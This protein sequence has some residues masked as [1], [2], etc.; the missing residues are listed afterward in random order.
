MRTA[1][2]S[3]IVGGTI[4]GQLRES[5]AAHMRPRIDVLE[6]ETARHATVLDF[7]RLVEKSDHNF[8]SHRP[9]QVA[10]ATRQWSAVLATQVLAQI[11]DDD[12]VY[13]TGEDV[14]FPLAILMQARGIRRPAL[15]VRLEEPTYGRTVWRR[16]VFDLYRHYALRR[17]D[18][19][20]CR[21]TAHSQYLNAIDRVSAGKLAVVGETVDTEFFYPDAP[22]LASLEAPPSPFIVSAGLERRDYS[23][24]IDAVRGLPLR[25]IIAAGSPW[26][27][28]SF[29]GSDIQSMPENVQ[30]ASFTA[31]EMREL[32]RRA[33]FVV[34]PVR[35]TLRACGM[36]VVLEAWAMNRAVIA[37]RTAGLMDYITDGFSGLFVE[38]FD[39]TG[40]R[41]AIRDLMEQPQRA[42]Y[43]GRNGRN[44]VEGNRN[45]T[46]FVHRMGAILDEAIS[47]RG[48]QVAA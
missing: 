11:E 2:T 8:W 16:T 27:H 12:V 46:M 9:L 28:A 31:C 32:Y 23:T 19:L 24:L 26:S 15:V 41:A 42:A 20:V 43:L 10:Q 13:A 14:G 5:V 18:R 33:A 25:L 29:R 1:K 7:S 40:L 45:L 44:I 47:G 30:V 36:N 34:V 22:Q 39:A 37:T 21:T 48:S 17:I 3:I 6:M 35:P 38:P 4:D